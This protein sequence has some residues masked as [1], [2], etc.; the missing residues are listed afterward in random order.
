MKVDHRSIGGLQRRLGQ[1]KAADVLQHV[2]GDALGD[3]TERVNRR[4][5]RRCRYLLG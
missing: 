3:S 4:G 5:R 2:S 1:E